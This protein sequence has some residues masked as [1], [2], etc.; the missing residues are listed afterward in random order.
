M[1]ER[2]D[3]PSPKLSWCDLFSMGTGVYPDVYP[4]EEA[5]S[6]PDGPDSGEGRNGGEAPGGTQGAEAN[7]AL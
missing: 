7:R 1:N 6:P 5:Q 3:R 2:P 4:G